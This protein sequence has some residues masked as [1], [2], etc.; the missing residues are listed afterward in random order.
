VPLREPYRLAFGSVAAFD[1]LLVVLR[2]ASGNEGLG[3]AT[4]LTGYTDETIEE[5]W[6]IACVTARR[7]AADLAHGSALLARLAATH[8]FTATAFRTAFEMAAGSPWLAVRHP[9]AVPLAGLLDA[10]D[11]AAIGE[12]LDRLIDA[13]YGTIKIK[14]GF[15]AAADIARVRAVQRI[16]AGRVRIRIDA[17]Q[18]YSAQQA[19][20]FVRAL[21]PDGIEL[22]EQPCAAGDWTSHVAVAR[23]SHLPLMLDESIYGMQDIERAAQLEAAAYIKLKLMKTTSLADLAACLRRIRQLGMTPV[24]GNGVAC[25]PGCWM[26]ACVAAQ[27]VDTAGEMNGYLKTRASL[28][29]E[30]LAFRRGAIVLQPGFRPS[31]S[32]DAVAQL[33][34]ESPLQIDV[35]HRRGGSAADGSVHWTIAGDSGER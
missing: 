19:M 26:E 22:F 35:R 13:G 21:E 27:C 5:S 18:G 16:A 11:E 20:A 6:R 23:M 24:L 10:H 14:V 30:R 4:I 28:L 34:V 17:N 12:A 1:T 29:S 2:D 3:E 7:L 15:D 32:R 8:P 25:D 33:Q 9:V 31:L